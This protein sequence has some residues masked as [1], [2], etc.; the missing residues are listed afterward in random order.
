M[1]P[2]DIAHLVTLGRPSLSP[3]GAH[4]VVAATRPDL[5]ANDY[6]S[7]LWLV[8]TDG[9]APPR[10]LTHGEH[11]T[12]PRWSPDGATIAFL[13]TSGTGTG[14]QGKPQ[15]HLLPAA[16]GDARTV[17]ELVGGAG[18]P[19]WSPDSRRVAFA[20]RVLADGRYGQDD[21]VPAE[22]EA[23]RRITGLQY[24]TDDVGFVLDRRHHLFVVDVTADE[25]R[26][27]QLTD[28][29]QDD[30]A[31]AWRPDGAALAFVSRRHAGRELDRL[32]DVFVV[33]A[34]GGDVRAVTDTTMQL[35]LP[36][37]SADGTALFATGVRPEGQDW[38]ARN[39]GLWRVDAA[40]GTPTRL[41]D[42]ETVH[43]A[44]LPPVVTG[45]E[46]LVGVENR[47]AVDLL[48]VATDGS[49]TRVASAGRRQVTG[50]DRAAGVTV[51]TYSD[52]DTAGEL[53][54]VA[55]DGTVTTL[56]SFAT[57]GLTRP[58]EE[59]TATAPDGYPVHGFVSVPAGAGPHPVLLLI[60]GGPFSQYGWTMLDEV[61]VYTAAGYAVV[62]GNPRGSSGYGQAHGRHIVGDVGERSAPD[63]LALLDAGLERPDL[64]A[65]RV[66]VLGGSHG[67]FMTTWLVGHTDRFRAAVS[68]RAVN[69][70]D[71]FE[72]SSDIG[73]DFA[74]NLYGT[75]PDQRR[76]QSP[77]TTADAISTPLLVVHSEHDWRCPVEQAQRLYVALR[78]RGAEVELLLFPGEGH[79]LSR[80]GVP[81][82]RV[83]RF[84]AV[85][86]W[87]DRYLS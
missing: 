71:S 84:E 20:A 78:R 5:D 38:I 75:D 28:G 85:V 81:G 58:V 65:T 9:A 76:R 54:R 17:T 63:L 3:D 8:P 34:G 83:A 42:T 55:D 80:S 48:A 79:E 69:A 31:P 22:K 1:Q 13:R 6:R 16:G 53:A 77:L 25:P 64:D 32:T 68:E 36:V 46:V 14:A 72:G 26:A 18:E 66:G 59:L 37:W 43:V 29:D 57:A 15:L 21:D 70:I 73:W 27:E 11:D 30:T 51:V 24:R 82:H 67:G 44:A 2:S 41:T 49:A 52:T 61:H 7:S 47:G 50:V 60:H 19:V 35:D 4:A 10:R 40:G 74:D 86:D 45:D 23:P 56:T 33:P 87:F 62:F 39:E 12:A